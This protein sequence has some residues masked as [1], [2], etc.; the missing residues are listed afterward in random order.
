[1]QL[2]FHA[3][4]SITAC[5]SRL[6][7]AIHFPPSLLLH[8][9]N[10]R[11]PPA[12]L[13]SP[14]CPLPSPTVRMRHSSAGRFVACC[15]RY[16]CCGLLSWRRRCTARAVLVRCSFTTFRTGFTAPSP[17]PSL[18]LRCSFADAQDMVQG[19]GFGSG[20]AVVAAL[21]F[22]FS[23]V[24]MFCLPFRQPFALSVSAL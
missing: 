24:L 7:T 5:R 16:V 6:I 10:P 14:C 18:F 21:P 15:P 9:R 13:Q 4:P 8:C 19:Q 23:S 2:S 12:P 17:S 22:L 1:M 3:R 11:P 20:Q